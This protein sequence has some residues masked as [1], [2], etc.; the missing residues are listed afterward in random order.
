MNDGQEEYLIAIK[1]A[2]ERNPS[3][4]N[5]WEK[6]FLGDNME[7][8]TDEGDE[9]Y[10]SKRQWEIIQRIAKEKYGIDVDAYV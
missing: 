7:R 3:A 10:F 4:C 1:Q 5:D 8:F 6:G 2:W 9:T